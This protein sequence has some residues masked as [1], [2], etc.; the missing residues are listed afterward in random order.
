MSYGCGDCFEPGKRVGN[1]V[2]LAGYVTNARRELVGWTALANTCPSF[3]W[4]WRWLV[5]RQ[6]GKMT[7]LKHV[8]EV[9]HGLIN[10]QELPVVGATFLLRRAEFPG[11]EGEGLPRA[12][13]SLLEDSTHGGSWSIRDQGKWNRRIRV[14]QKSSSIVLLYTRRKLWWVLRSRWRDGSP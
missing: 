7:G 8:A 3:V 9:S 1:D 11:K 4:R 2:V 14:C 6:N 12:L 13:R 10:R 5:A